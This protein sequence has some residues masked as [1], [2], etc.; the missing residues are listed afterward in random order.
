MSSLCLNLIPVACATS[1]KAITGR[2]VLVLNTHN[3]RTL[4]LGYNKSSGIVDASI[5]PNVVK[6]YQKRNKLLAFGC[7]DCRGIVTINGNLLDK[8]TRRELHKGD[9]VKLMSDENDSEYFYCVANDVE[10]QEHE[11][12]SNATT[13]YNTSGTATLVVETNSQES[14]AT[15][16][17]A[18]APQQHQ[19]VFPPQISEDTMCAICMEILMEPQTFVPCGHSFCKQCLH[20]QAQCAE[21]R[22]PVRGTVACR[23]LQ[24]LID[25]LIPVDTQ[26]STGV[27]DREDLEYYNRRKQKKDRS[28]KTRETTA[29]SRKRRRQMQRELVAA[30]TSANNDIIDLA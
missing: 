16:P 2:P 4:F 1:T 27:F 24:N 12:D 25:D 9:V 21:C 20:Q 10:E 28:A 14:T 18:S 13:G 15:W 6:I 19:Q 3:N 22:G 5:S 29:P 17:G 7:R 30:G 23:S 11:G 26:T 8:G